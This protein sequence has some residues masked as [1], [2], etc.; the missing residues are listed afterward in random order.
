MRIAI[1]GCGGMG[2]VHAGE[3]AAMPGVELV[4]VCDIEFHLA[5]ELAAKTGAQA[6]ST[7]EEMMSIVKPEVVSLTLPSYLHKE[8]ICRSAQLG[9]HIICEKPISLTEEDAREAIS[10]CEQH[11]V[12]LFLG[13]V[14]R[15]FPEYAQIKEAVN[16]GVL[17]RM[18]VVHLKRVGSHPGTAREWYFDEEKSG[19][20]IVD[21]MIHDIDFALSTLGEPKSVYTLRRIWE[22]SDYALI[23]LVFQNGAVAHLEGYWGDPGNFRTSAEYAGSGGIIRADSEKSRS[24]T[25]RRSRLAPEGQRFA[26]IPESPLQHSPYYL[27]LEHFITCIRENRESTVTPEDAC[28]ALIVANAAKESAV[29]GQAVHFGHRFVREAQQ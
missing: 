20:V 3:F 27:E 22:A 13:H 17:G 10:T 1:A 19:G 28:R 5:K 21:L 15:F 7:Y 8:Y 26:E 12:K 14:V 4:G 16:A 24:V 18:G 23:T 11:G 25:I 29:T 6:F 9:V 2:R